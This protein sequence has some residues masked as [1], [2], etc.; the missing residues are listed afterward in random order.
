MSA[1]HVTL[2][3]AALPL[4]PGSHLQGVCIVLDEAVDD[5]GTP[6][7]RKAGHEICEWISRSLGK[8]A[9]LTG[10]LRYEGYPIDCV[11]FAGICKIQNTRKAWMLWM[12]ANHTIFDKKP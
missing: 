3:K 4:L 5:I 7:L 1:R 2:L 6:R 8:N 10:W 12:I 11:S 9:Y